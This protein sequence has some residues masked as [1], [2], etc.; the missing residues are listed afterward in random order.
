MIACG[1]ELKCSF[2]FKIWCE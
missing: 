2:S 1:L